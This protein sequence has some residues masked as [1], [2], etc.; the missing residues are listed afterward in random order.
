[1]LA[2]AD[3]YEDP[4]TRT[5]FKRF[6]FEP[7]DA[8][9]GP[10]VIRALAAHLI[11]ETKPSGVARLTEIGYRMLRPELQRLRDAAER[12]RVVT[13]EHATPVLPTPAE[14]AQLVQSLGR[15]DY[16]TTAAFVDGRLVT[17]WADEGLERITGYTVQTL[18]EAGGWPVVLR[19][20]REEE[21]KRLFEQLL[22]GEP[23]SGEL[24]LTRRDGRAVRVEFLTLPRWDEARTAVIGTVNGGR[25]VARAR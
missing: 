11:V 19:A 16:L 9:T 20:V 18:E 14:T 23:V 10:E 1:M 6:E 5:Q 4:L 24:T 22:G 25:A 2:L 15:L 3:L 21:L 12:H 7:A 8:R 17:S 13:A